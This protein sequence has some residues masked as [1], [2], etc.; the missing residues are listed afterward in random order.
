[1]IAQNIA[2][3][4][5]C[6]PAIRPTLLD[7][8]E[9][10]CD[11]G[12]SPVQRMINTMQLSFSPKAQYSCQQSVL[13]GGSGNG[14]DVTLP[15]NTNCSTSPYGFNSFVPHSNAAMPA[16][17]GTMSSCSLHV[18]AE[19]DC[20]GDSQQLGMEDGLQSGMCAFHGGRSA[21]VQCRA[22]SSQPDGQTYTSIHHNG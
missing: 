19:A 21:Q 16:G 14:T 10:Y 18:Y 6:S 5:Y 20:T 12:T 22:A 4:S 9:N 15:L 11:L 2:P 3:P 13:P 7:C 17:D 1:M 8:L